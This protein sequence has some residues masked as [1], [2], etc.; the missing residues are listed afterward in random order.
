MTSGREP[1]TVNRAAAR[2]R[3]PL[4]YKQHQQGVTFNNNRQS[5]S[6]SGSNART[7]TSG[8]TRN[9]SQAPTT[10]YASRS[11]GA[12]QKS[13]FAFDGS[14]HD[15]PATL[16]SSKRK[17]LGP[18]EGGKSSSFLPR[19]SGDLSDEEEEDEQEEDNETTKKYG[20]ED[21]DDGNSVTSSFIENTLD[22]PPDDYDANECEAQRTG[23]FNEFD[24]DCVEPTL[25]HVS[26]NHGANHVGGLHRESSVLPGGASVANQHQ[27]ARATAA[28]GSSSEH[29]V[30]Q[31][32]NGADDRYDLAHN[33]NDLSKQAKHI[34][35]WVSDYL[36]HHIKFIYTKQVLAYDGDIHGQFL[37]DYK[38]QG[39][40]RMEKE[41]WWSSI[42]PMVED[43]LRT[44]RNNCGNQLF[45]AFKGMFFFLTICFR[46]F[47]PLVS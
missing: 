39:D 44:K 29:E 24:D 3:P 22:N 47:F 9:G 33:W 4:T 13:P 2:P 41:A 21:L 1:R 12:L 16:H 20:D 26:P 43:K 37:I 38:E 6:S 23:R 30:Q 34:E 15:D 10:P 17:K 35:W 31:L 14:R 7:T 45:E 25:R 36:F 27:Q 8:T 32:E 28:R 5:A 11:K 42:W 19:G 40:T 46:Y 18:S